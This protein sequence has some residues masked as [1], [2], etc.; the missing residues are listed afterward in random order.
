[1]KPVVKNDDESNESNELIF[2][3]FVK[4]ITE[5]TTEVPSEIQNIIDEHFW[6]LL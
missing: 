1:M 4:K 5:D 3:E 2:E 6:E